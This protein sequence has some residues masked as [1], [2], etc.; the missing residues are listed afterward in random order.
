MKNQMRQESAPQVRYV[1]EF[2]KKETSIH[3]GLKDKEVALYR[4]RDQ[5]HTK[6]CRQA[7]F[8]WAQQK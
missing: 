3:T 7:K 6:H 8:Q 5:N 4:Y 1:K 2:S